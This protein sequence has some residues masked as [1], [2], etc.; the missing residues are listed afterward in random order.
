MSDLKYKSAEELREII[1]KSVSY[2]G[3]LNEEASSKEESISLLQEEIRAIKSRANNSHQRQV[4]ARKYL[5]EKPR[6]DFV[7]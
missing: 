4:W 3:K 7:R 6:T 2:I 1:S 5:A